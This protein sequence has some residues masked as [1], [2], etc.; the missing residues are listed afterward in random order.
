[1]TKLFA[2]FFKQLVPKQK[3]SSDRCIQRHV[4]Q[5][6]KGARRET[7]REREKAKELG[8][9]TFSLRYKGV[10]SKVNEKGETVY[11]WL[12]WRAAFL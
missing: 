8:V 7:E 6:N 5:A 1:M 3:Y 11:C 12:V 4:G 2:N 9:V 10:Q